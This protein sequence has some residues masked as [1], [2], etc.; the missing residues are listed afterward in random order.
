MAISAVFESA[1]KQSLADALT[2][3][4]ELLAR[5][6]L[7]HRAWD[8][9]PVAIAE[10]SRPGRTIKVLRRS[11][12]RL[13]SYELGT[14]Q[15][16]QHFQVIR[17]LADLDANLSGNFT[18]TRIPFVQDMQSQISLGMAVALKKRKSISGLRWSL[19]SLRA[20]KRSSPGGPCLNSPQSRFDRPA[21]TGDI[22]RQISM[23]EPFSPDCGPSA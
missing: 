23:L 12:A 2:D 22:H 16:L 20:A 14:A 4:Q 7:P 3:S 1:F 5:N 19:V 11:A 9:H 13:F 10:K 18:R 21:K 6:A 15:F 17:G 8:L